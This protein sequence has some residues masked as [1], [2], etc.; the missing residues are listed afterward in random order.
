MTPTPSTQPR[1]HPA[2]DTLLQYAAGRLPAGQSLVV[3]THLIACPQCRATVRLCE[4]V[5]GALLADEAPAT[6]AADLLTRTLAR[7]EPPPSAPPPVTA[8]TELAPGLPMPAPLHGLSRG[9]WRW[10]APGISR[11]RIDVPGA[12]VGERAY[13]LRVAAGTR[14]PE[15]GHHGAE[16]TCVLAGQFTD[17][18]GTYGPGDVAELDA[19]QSHQPFAGAEAACICLI[20]TQGKLRMHH[21]LARLVQPLVGV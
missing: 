13:L 16:I 14:L 19:A 17:A 2:D 3:A 20:A 10:V 6:L 11:I 9:P 1:R 4:A 15:H 21:F 5:G 7:L 12:R 18:T 8:T